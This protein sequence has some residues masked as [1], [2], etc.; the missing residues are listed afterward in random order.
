VSLRPVMRIPLQTKLNIFEAQTEYY[1]NQPYLSD[2]SFVCLLCRCVFSGKANTVLCNQKEIRVRVPAI[3]FDYPK[4]SGAT[5]EGMT[6][7]PS[8][9]AYLVF[10]P[11]ETTVE[12]TARLIRLKRIYNF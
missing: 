11:G 7:G 5:D 2:A 1:S 12:G 9:F 6:N 8:I 10:G 4:H 3:V